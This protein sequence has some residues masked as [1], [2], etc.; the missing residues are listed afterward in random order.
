MLKGDFFKK[1]VTMP[2]SLTDL[3]QEENVSVRS[4]LKDKDKNEW[5]KDK[6]GLMYVE[7]VM[8]QR[9]SEYSLTLVKDKS[10]DAIKEI[11]Y[12][13]YANLRLR[14]DVCLYQVLSP[15]ASLPI[16]QVE[17]NSGETEHTYENARKKLIFCMIEQFWVLSNFCDDGSS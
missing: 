2:Y 15:D 7:K 11:M 5:D 12:P 8:G 17:V 16:L 4:C 9:M 3:L 13:V 14:P 6:A 1:E 10:V